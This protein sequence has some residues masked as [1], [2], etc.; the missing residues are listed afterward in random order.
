MK[1]AASVLGREVAVLEAIGDFKSALTYYPGCS[2][3]S[4]VSLTMPVRTQI[5]SRSTNGRAL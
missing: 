4:L 2:P 1:L 3:G 5:N